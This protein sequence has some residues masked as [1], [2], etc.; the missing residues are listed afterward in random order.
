MSEALS[1]L[2]SYVR[3]RLADQ[4][5]DVTVAYGELTVLV[6][7]EAIVDVVQFLRDDANCRFVSFIDVSGADYPA[8]EDRFDVVYH[9]LS[10]TRNL[11][12]RVKVR[13]DEDTPVPSVTSVFPGANWYERE[14]YD[15][16][17]VLF[18]GHP[19]LRRILTDYGFEGHPLRK[20]FPLTGFVEVRYDDEIK[21][22]V[23]EPVELKQEFRNFDFLSPWEGTDY[24]LP[25]DEKAKPN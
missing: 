16:Y 8:R 21:R 12:I 18:S 2:G 9:L 23:Y 4:V 11:R 10:P 3:E 20:D 15:L 22:V 25:G 13:T 7:R 1:S 24:V 14:V 17:G 6:V 19:E 5:L